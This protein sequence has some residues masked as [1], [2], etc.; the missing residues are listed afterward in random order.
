VTRLVAALVAA[1][2]VGA[3]EPLTLL[4][5][6]LSA[7]AATVNDATAD[8][9]GQPSPLLD[10]AGLR[11]FF[12]GN[13]LFNQT[14]V[15]APSSV[16]ERDGLGPLFNARSCSGCHLKDGRGGP[17]PPGQPLAT[18]L[19][20]VSGEPVYGDQIQGD[21]LPGVAP[22]AE[23]FVEWED[24]PGRYDDG[25][26]YVLRRPRLRF[27]RLGYGPLAPGAK[28]SPRVAPAMI[29]LGL[30]ESVPEGD[31]L[32]ASDPDDADGDGIS[33]RPNRV[34]A[35]G[36]AEWLLG[37]FG[38]KAEQ[39]TVRQQV[40]G[41]L[42]GDLGLTTSLFPRE[43]S[44]SL[45]PALAGVPSGGSP[46]VSERALAALTLYASS[47][48]VPAR[49]ELASP[50]VRRGEALFAELGCAGCHAP[51]LRTAPLAG[52]H[53]VRRETI[54]P[55]TDLLLHDLGEALADDRPVF[56]A[57]GREWRTPPLWGL[58]LLRTVSGRVEL[59]HDGRARS[60]AEAVLWHDGEAARAKQAFLASSRDRRAAL[61]AFL[62]SL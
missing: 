52:A 38:W 21:A 26:R 31:V 41:A 39:P 46:E 25:E 56:A 15:S 11:Q 19:V 36:R 32:A 6:R 2:G 24:V 58:G 17:P 29:G 44:T 3:A 10:A 5:S 40:A 30:L 62:E 8:A 54:H 27:E 49:R 48:G 59:L 43:N 42:N 12:V 9:F 22:E 33:G 53:G 37:R 60:A 28:L 34:P 23:I 50:E 1:L 18:M 14:W 20:R 57:S 35:S 55:Y 51:E 13:S 61:L 16:T 45:Q 47:L 4:P 7:G